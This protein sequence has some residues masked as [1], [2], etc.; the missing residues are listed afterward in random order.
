MDMS[1]FKNFPFT[2]RW[3]LQFRAEAFNV[4]NR[5]NFQDPN[6]TVA[7]GVTFGRITS[8][9]DPRVLQFALK[10]VF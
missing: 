3:R 9:N 5:P 2:E 1:L 4:E 6:S 10:L 7:A 8:A